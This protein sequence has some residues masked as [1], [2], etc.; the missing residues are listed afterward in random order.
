[1]VN[2][3][4]VR[5]KYI[6]YS[7]LLDELLSEPESNTIVMLDKAAILQNFILLILKEILQFTLDD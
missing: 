2:G 6:K 7:G 4:I 1:M 5:N 3:E